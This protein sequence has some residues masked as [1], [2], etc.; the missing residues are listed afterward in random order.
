[1]EWGYDAVLLNTAVAQAV[2]P[3]AMA[4]AFQKGIAAGRLAYLSGPMRPREHAVASTPLVDIPFWHHRNPVVEETSATA[5][6]LGE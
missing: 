2:N 3:V 5:S 1:M 4:E 6:N